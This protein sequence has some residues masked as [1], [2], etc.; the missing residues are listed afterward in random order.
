MNLKAETMQS[1]QRASKNLAD[2][3]AALVIGS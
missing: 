1:E 3:A 2:V